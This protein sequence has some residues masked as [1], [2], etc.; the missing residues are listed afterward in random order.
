MLPSMSEAYSGGLIGL[1]DIAEYYDIDPY[2]ISKGKIEFNGRNYL[3]KMNLTY[4]EI[5][6]VAKVAE[7][8][9]YLDGHVKWLNAAL[10]LA[11][12]DIKNAKQNIRKLKYVATLNTWWK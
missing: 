7:D 12:Q 8:Q 2:D 10:R 11:N 3:S 1:T 6:L 5:I 4:S 9:N